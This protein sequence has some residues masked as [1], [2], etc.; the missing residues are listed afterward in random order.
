M[1]EF[2]RQVLPSG[3]LPLASE[4]DAMSRA[5]DALGPVLWILPDGEIAEK[6]EK[7]PLRNRAAWV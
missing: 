2:Q 1:T 4:E 5:L 7:Y 3:G 6:T